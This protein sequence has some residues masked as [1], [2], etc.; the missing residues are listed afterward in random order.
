MNDN[1]KKL[2]QYARKNKEGFTV[3]LKNGKLIPIKPSNKSRYVVADKTVIIY[4]PKNKSSKVF[5][6]IEP[7]RTYGGW[8][9]KD[10]KK[11]LIETNNLYSNE[12]TAKRIGKMR[13]QKAI[14]DLKKMN[15]IRLAYAKNQ[16]ITGIRVNQKL[17]IVTKR[18]G[19]YYNQLTGKYTTKSTADKI[20][21]YFRK[22]P[23]GT[24]YEA[25]SQPKYKK[26]EKWE[27]QSNK[28]V[29]LY[30]KEIQVIKTKDRFGNDVY[31]SPILKK[32]ITKAQ[33]KQ[34]RKYDFVDG[35]FKISL[36]RMTA[37]KGRVYHILKTHIG[38]TFE[39]QEDIDRLEKK[40]TR[41][42]TPEAMRL[43][44]YIA[45]KYPL[46]NSQVM[47]VAFNHEFYLV[48]FGHSEQGAVTVMKSRQPHRH[49]DQFP[50][51]IHR[52]F[53]TYRA[54]LNTYRVITVK[55]VSIYIY[56]FP[57]DETYALSENRLGVFNRNGNS[58]R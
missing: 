39:E 32:R 48:N 40:F 46:H 1:E 27:K 18:K 52:A 50:G 6:K 15:E 47:Y 8:Y 33:L 41:D 22:H 24:L 4:T 9:D 11:Y 7:N 54:L 35:Q 19:K 20:N 34:A 44:R 49:L 13:R 10:S 5:G 43:V 45:R 26:H 31:Y 36:Y 37:D 55:D 57:T 28:I 38:R 25:H 58:K 53:M 14:F 3:T 30:K 29:D 12:S 17:D 51:E 21:R 16:R 56:S 2:I 42:W 23:D